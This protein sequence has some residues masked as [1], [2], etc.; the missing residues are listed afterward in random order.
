MPLPISLW[1]RL[2]CSIRTEAY[3]ILEGDRQN[4]GRGGEDPAAIADADNNLSPSCMKLAATM[5]L[6][7]GQESSLSEPR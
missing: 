6:A 4:G 1:M 3:T 5:Q 7:A 2:I